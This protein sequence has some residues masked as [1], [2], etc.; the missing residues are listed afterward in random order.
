M[1]PLSLGIA[2]LALLGRLYMK[3]V[4]NGWV[5]VL[6]HHLCMYVCHIT[7]IVSPLFVTLA[8]EHAQMHHY[9]LLLGA[10]GIALIVV[11]STTCPG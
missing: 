3:D 10:T 5:N 8:S 2:V 11:E 1:F 7:C 6:T 4:A 9:P